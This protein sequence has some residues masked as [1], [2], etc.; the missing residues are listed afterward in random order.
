MK[1]L[2]VL[3]LILFSFHFSFPKKLNYHLV[4]EYLY[5]DEKDTFELDLFNRPKIPSLDFG[6]DNENII[7][8]LL[9]LLTQ[10]FLYYL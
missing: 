7:K 8:L 4:F 2:F 10:G 5:S 3:L 9:E 6:E 1:T